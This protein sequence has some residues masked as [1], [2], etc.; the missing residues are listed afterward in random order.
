MNQQER[1]A[2][3]VNGG[4]LILKNNTDVI[5]GFKNGYLYDFTKKIMEKSTY[6]LYFNKEWE[7]YEEPKWH[8]NIPEHGVLCWVGCSDRPVKQ[9]RIAIVTGINDNDDSY[10]TSIGVAWEKAIPLTNEE[11][12]KFMVQDDL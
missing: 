1:W 5:I 12:K 10:I 3:L 2:H 7:I 8:K 4:K 6:S 11:I 9:N